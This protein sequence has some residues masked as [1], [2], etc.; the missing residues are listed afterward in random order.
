MKK[1]ILFFVIVLMVSLN[2]IS[3]AEELKTKDLISTNKIWMI[4]FNNELDYTT[5]NSKNIY[6]KDN[7]GNKIDI[8][9]KLENSKKKVKIIPK[10]DYEY[11]AKYI[12]YVDKEVKD[13]N[14]NGLKE[15]VTMN[16]ITEKD[17]VIE[18]E[19]PT[20]EKT[21]RD[22]IDEPVGNI[23]M[24]EVDDIRELNI[25][26]PSNLKGIQ[27]LTSL[28]KL[29]IFNDEDNK[30]KNLTN[31]QNLI[32]L[33]TLYINDSNIR[34]TSFLSD[35]VNLETLH[36]EN[37]KITDIST[38]SNLTNLKNLDITANEVN[39]ISSLKNLSNLHCL[40]AGNN[41]ISDINPLSSLVNL[42]DLC[43]NTN[44]ISDISPLSKLAKLE[45]LNLENNQISDVSALSKLT[46]LKTVDLSNNQIKDISGLKNL[47]HLE[48]LK[49][50]F[51]EIE[52]EGILDEFNKTHIEK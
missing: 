30:I 36:L 25:T 22:K 27:Y 26:R 40:R 9:V 52:D 41:K 37:N 3:Y 12:F 45:Y 51:N 10:S 6:V 2:C 44:Q 7:Y 47:P 16:L 20:L 11:N 42:E 32:N 34:D 35:L 23:Y 14:G 50:Y 43:I 1:K 21:I 46:N 24:S 8:E 18:F 5:V 33:R 38:L 15:L 13:I 29:L 19:D 31:I 17:E 49:I 4:Q 48:I 28:E 39:H